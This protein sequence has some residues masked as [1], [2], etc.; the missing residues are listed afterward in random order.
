VS[1]AGSHLEPPDTLSAWDLPLVEVEPP[2]YRCHRIA[3][4]AIFF[5]TSLITPRHEM[6]CVR[7]QDRR[8]GRVGQPDTDALRQGLTPRRSTVLA[9]LR[10][11]AGHGRAPPAHFWNTVDDALRLIEVVKSNP[12][13]NG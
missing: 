5:N 9:R 10:L 8:R 1:S 13:I 6:R 7:G 11:Q 4:D 2:W 3:R 12:R